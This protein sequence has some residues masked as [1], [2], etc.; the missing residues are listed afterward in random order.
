MSGPPPKRIGKYELGERIAAGGMAEVYLA[1]LP[2]GGN[3][4]VALKVLHDNLSRDPAHI[5]MFQD[6][7]RLLAKLYHPST[8]QLYE[9]GEHQGRHFM[10]MELLI[11]DSLLRVWHSFHEHGVKIP[12]PVACFIG[13][14]VAEGLHHAHELR[15]A[16]G[17]PENVVHRDVNPSNIQITFDGRIKILDFGL[18]KSESK[19]SQTATGI[20]KGKLGYLSPEQVD[21]Q[22]PDRRADI[23]ALGTTLWEISVDR[24]L[25]RE[26]SDVGTIRRIQRCE[27][28][29]PRTLVPDYPTPLWTVLRSALARDPRQRYQTAEQMAR[30]LYACARQL[31]PEVT[32]QTISRMMGQVCAWAG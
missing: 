6:E 5:T 32:G 10:A 18:A 16:R 23:F 13:A 7:A 29:D 2:Q 3:R 31:G 21:G 9:A 17:W 22:P 4:M 12:Y 8:V 24:R 1:R 26:D 19:A 30:D 14:K 15:D 11:G 25:F 27:V 28:P 20:V